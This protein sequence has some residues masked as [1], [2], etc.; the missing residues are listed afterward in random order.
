[1]YHCYLSTKPESWLTYSWLFTT[2]F[3]IYILYILY[4]EAVSSILKTCHANYVC[5]R[6]QCLLNILCTVR[7]Q[8]HTL[9][10][11]SFLTFNEEYKKAAEMK[12]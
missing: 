2:S 8:Q 12:I 1:M 9:L 10:H 4:L 6:I 7:I 5:K 11:V 3:S